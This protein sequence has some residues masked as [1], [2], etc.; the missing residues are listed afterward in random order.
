MSN[1]GDIVDAEIP[2]PGRR[3]RG[4]GLRRLLL[5]LLFLCIAVPAGLIELFRFVQPPHTPLMLFYGGPVTQ[6]W[7]PLESISPNLV[8]AVIASEDT[9]FCSHIG[10]DFDAIDQALGE[11]AAGARLRGASTIS[12]QTAK[13]LFLLPDR[14]W[15]RKGIEAYL[16]VLLEALWP[17]RR[18]LETYLNIAEWGD[19]RFGAET[20][21]Q[22]NFHKPAWRL[23][24]DEAARLATILPNPREYRA[25]PPSRY[26]MQ[27]S[28]IILARMKDVK[29]DELDA[30]II[31]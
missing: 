16:T 13:N 10:F 8:Q 26:V 17:K 30:C 11:N 27:Q 20:A 24:A 9:K 12:Q 23:T 25:E 3:R 29:R 4:R 31:Q 5:G 21:A 22:G 14:S 1:H 6:Q 18:I 7:M 15:A 28:R 2:H 19:G